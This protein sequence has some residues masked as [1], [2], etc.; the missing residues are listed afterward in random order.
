MCSDFTSLATSVHGGFHI[1]E[2]SY[3]GLLNR[4]TLLLP[5]WWVPPVQRNM[6][7]SAGLKCSPGHY[8]PFSVRV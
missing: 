7:P 8:N 2:T 6:P 4:D 5:G 3:C 1:G